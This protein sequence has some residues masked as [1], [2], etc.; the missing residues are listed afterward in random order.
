MYFIIHSP[1]ALSFT[2]K[3]F[4]RKVGVLKMPLFSQSGMYVLKGAVNESQY[5]GQKI[6]YLS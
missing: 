3:D 5:S 4:P 1:E 2:I 6:P